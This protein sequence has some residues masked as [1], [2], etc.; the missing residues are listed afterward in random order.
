MTGAKAVQIEVQHSP[1]LNT[2]TMVEETL[3]SAEKMM[4]AAE[5]KR[6][7]P[8]KVMHGTLVQILDYLQASGKIFISSKGILWTYMPPE[9]MER[10]MKDGL[11]V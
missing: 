2:I 9:Q 5:L 1:T 7:L 10:W 8:R 3:K 6:C 4:T 11:K